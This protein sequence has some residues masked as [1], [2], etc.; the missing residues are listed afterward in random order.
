MQTPRG[1]RG[2]FTTDTAAR[3]IYSEGAGIFRMIPAAVALPSDREDLITLVRWAASTGTPLV[4]RGA[5]SG[6]GGGNVGRGVVVDLTVACAA[7]PVVDPQRRRARAGA[8]VTC[9]AL[10]GAAAG[11]GLRLP[12]DPS[13]AG[14]CTLGGMVAC[15]AAGPHSLR[16]GAMRRWVRALE[17][18]TADGETGKTERTELAEGTEG[19]AAEQ[20]FRGQVAPLIEQARA[21]LEARR[22][23]TR[24]NSSGY[25]LLP[26]EDGAW[27]KNLLVGSEG[28]LA[29]V[30]AVEV[31][32]APLPPEPTTLLITLRSLDD[33]AP[34]LRRL[35]PFEPEAIEMLDRTFLDFVRAAAH[36]RIPAGT[37][38]VLIVELA[39]DAAPAASAASDLAS[40]V[41]QAH[42]ASSAGKLWEI[43]HL[44]SPLLAALPDNMRSLQ[45]V[46]DG[47]VPAE[48][49]GEYVAAVRRI[50]TECGFEVVIFG[51]AGDAN[52]HANL[53]A[54]VGAPDFVSRLQQCLDAV[55]KLQLSLGGTPSGEHGDGRLRAPYVGRLFG[56]TYLEL[57]RAVKRAFDPNGILNPG[58]KLPPESTATSIEPEI[59]KVGS[60]APTLPG[61][62]TRALRRIEREAAWHLPRLQ[63]L[64]ELGDHLTPD[65]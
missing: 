55:T 63:L 3:A 27:V 37:E 11:Y 7:P 9:R 20:R 24:K 42:D 52:V 12:P 48:A 17:F 59:L 23:R 38:A 44:A 64:A 45:V 41:T 57:A 29:I 22:P 39:A 30:T 36:A 28:T 56:E 58:V 35:E 53:L 21:E 34:M 62:I 51:H 32:L 1:F 5:G 15:N 19:T 33:L 50:A 25:D 18:V 47:C 46:E 49:L 61:E 43:R 26:P 13:S 8:A 4:P 60:R 2:A 40:S 65:P 10:N 6:M 54:D 14:F 31:D 16:Y